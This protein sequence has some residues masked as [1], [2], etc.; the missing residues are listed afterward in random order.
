MKISGRGLD[1]F[2]RAPRP[3]K[4][5]ILVYGP[6]Q[7]LVRERAR[8]LAGKCVDD[9]KD[10]FSVCEFTGAQIKADP[11]CLSDAATALSLTGEDRVIW[12]RDAGDTTTAPLQTVEAGDVTSWPIIV[13]AGE[14]APRSSLRKFFESNKNAAAIACYADEGRGL[15]R[16]FAETLANEGLTANPEAMACLGT[17]LGGDRLIIRGELEK[18]A[19][20]VKSKDDAPT[21]VT[22]DDVLACI[23]DSSSAPLDNLVYAVGNGDQTAID[24]ALNRAFAEGL[25]PVAIIRA[26]QR[27][28]HRLHLVRGQIDQG[29]PADTA[30]SG[31]RP[32]IF[33]KW[34][35]AFQRQS[36]IWTSAR[37]AGALDLA[38]E[39]E[40][41]C[42]STGMP[43]EVLCNRA[44]MRIAQGARSH[45][46]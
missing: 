27:H 40:M 32:P 8:L 15:E 3:S 33:F 34:K 24:T 39:C 21:V 35:S 1:D 7:G 20:Y 37:I 46:K 41:Q 18:L 13:E 36:Q 11:A 25:N 6:D 42:K 9:L 38:T 19:L 23:G 14:L 22:G 45:R 29:T 26:V 12:L 31:L 28:F 10:P 2:L 43:A 17:V 5:F 16:V 44:L 30:L 4:N